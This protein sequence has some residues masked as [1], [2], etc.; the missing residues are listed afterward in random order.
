MNKEFLMKYLSTNSPSSFE[1]EGQKV[2]KEYMSNFTD[3]FISDNYGSLAVL[4]RSKKS[5]N[6][7]P[8]KVVIEAHADEIG[9]LVFN[10]TDEGLIYVKC[11]GGIDYSIVPGTP[12][13]IMG[14]KGL[15]RGVFGW[16]PVHLNHGD[17]KHAPNEEKVFIDLGASNKDEVESMG[18]SIGDYVVF[19]RKPEIYNETKIISKSLDDKIGGFVIAEVL[20]ELTEQN[21]EL[22]FDLYIVNAVQE[23]VGL[24]GAKMI[25]E[26]I[27]PDVAICID[28]C[29]DTTNPLVE[30]KKVGDYKI[31]DGVVFSQAPAIQ[32]N[33]LNLMKDVAKEHE[34]KYKMIISGGQTGTDTDMY[35][36]SNGGVI[37]SLISIPVKYMHTPNEM[38]SLDDVQTAIN[39]YVE[40]LKSIQY[41]H[42]FKYF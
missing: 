42:N 39:F 14:S 9:W 34:I 2:W 31:G 17:N 26:T 33:L 41:K 21:I 28:V 25:T 4:V 18:V 35:T 10:I 29:H 38:A 27:K 20:R 22:P 19:D 23:E 16:I 40:L 6:H 11:N 1:V 30:K 15:V 5:I 7:N 36:L 37:S 12:V 3:E 8:Y 32:R 24:R 13:N